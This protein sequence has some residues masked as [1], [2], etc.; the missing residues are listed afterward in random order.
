M[1][2]FMRKLLNHSFVFFVIQIVLLTGLNFIREGNI[3]WPY[4]DISGSCRFLG[5][6]LN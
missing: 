2:Y 4:I 3:V 1:N 6:K 5:I